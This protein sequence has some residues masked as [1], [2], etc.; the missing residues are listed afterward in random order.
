M[1]E[2]TPTSNGKAEPT[3]A[4]TPSAREREPAAPH[5]SGPARISHGLAPA[6]IIAIA[7]L[8][9]S[10]WQWTDAQHESTRLE[11]DLARKVAEI[12]SSNKE[13][14]HIADEVRNTVRDLDSRMSLMEAKLTASENQRIALESLY[15][16]LA[17]NRDEWV[18]AE[19]EQILVTADEQLELAGNVR[20]ALI[21]LEAADK[22]LAQADRPGLLSLRKVI[23]QDIDKLKAAP[24]VDVPGLTLKIDALIAS[25]DDLPLLSDLRPTATSPADH[26]GHTPTWNNLLGELWYDLK[27]MLRIRFVDSRQAPLLAPE[28]A[29]FAREN[30]KLKL[31]SARLALLSRNESEFRMDIRTADQWLSQHFDTANAAVSSARKQLLQLADT[32]LAVQLPNIDDSLQAVRRQLSSPRGSVR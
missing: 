5:A 22:R 25:V 21:A 3:E 11:T 17:R 28:Q 15:Q 18:L 13:T 20:S 31:L 9:F 10:V 14:R 19:I 26:G 29:Y 30:L 23:N 7:A 8:G 12:E 1:S 24:A 6:L 4:Q 27:D 16:E 2:E 32:D